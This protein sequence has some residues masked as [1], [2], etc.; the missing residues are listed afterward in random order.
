MRTSVGPLDVPGWIGQSHRISA[1]RL[2]G[3]ESVI[4]R[5]D[6]KS[7]RKLFRLLTH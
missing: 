1:R 6:Q 7:G 5:F 4:R 3:I 2:G